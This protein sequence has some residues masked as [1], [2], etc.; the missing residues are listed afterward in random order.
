MGIDEGNFEVDRETSIIY[1]DEG[2][3][4]QNCVQDMD[5]ATGRQLKSQT[6][7]TERLPKL[8]NMSER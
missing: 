1:F 5:W 2:R 3:A 8:I 7:Q 6:K 4:P